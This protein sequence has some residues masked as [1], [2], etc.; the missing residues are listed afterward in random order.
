MSVQMLANT[1]LWDTCPNQIM[2]VMH[3]G[4]SCDIWHH[5]QYV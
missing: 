2:T 1:W 5:D 3:L 4:L